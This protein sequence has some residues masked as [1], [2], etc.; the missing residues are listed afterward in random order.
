ML[1]VC[2]SVG[3]LVGLPVCLSVCLSAHVRFSVCQCGRL[4]LMNL[5]DTLPR[6]LPRGVLQL[7]LSCGAEHPPSFIAMGMITIFHKL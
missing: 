3:R 5:T 6:F 2:R 4:L 1:S 7:L